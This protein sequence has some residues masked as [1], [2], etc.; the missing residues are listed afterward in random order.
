MGSD[1]QMLLLLLQFVRQSMMSVFSPGKPRL[2]EP[3]LLLQPQHFREH[4]HQSS[5]LVETP[6]AIITRDPAIPTTGGVTFPK[7]SCLSS[8]D[9]PSAP[10]P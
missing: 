5:H 2:L 7:S 8:E 9:M 1:D 10:Y 6:F 3:V 4:G